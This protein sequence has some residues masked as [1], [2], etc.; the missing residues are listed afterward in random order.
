M[1]RLDQAINE[2]VN[3]M[4]PEDRIDQAATRVR[5]KLF[6]QARNGR[7]TG[8]AVAP[9]IRPSFPP[10]WTGRL[11]PAR[12]LLLQDHTRECPACRHALERARAG[13]VRTLRPSGDA[14]LAHHPEMV[15]DRRDARADTRRRS[16]HRQPDVL[17]GQRPDDGR[18]RAGHPLFGVG[19]RRDADLPGREIAEGQKIR[20]AKGSTAMVRLADGSLVELNERAEISVGRALRGTAIRLDR[21]NIIVQAA[22]QRHGTLDVLTPDC[23]V[24]VKGTIFAVDRGMKGSRVSVVEGS[25]QVAQGAAKQS[26]EA[27]PAGHHR[28]QCRG[29][30]GPGCD[31]MEPRFRAIPGLA[32][33]IQ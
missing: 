20:T 32:R 21:G 30:L 5:Q 12:A 17:R 16:A 6:P 11:T 33:R 19:P 9:I 10:I 13:N 8:S 26:A 14:P 4:I 2:I 27:R 29:H 18:Q 25:V 3:E 15:G 24:S 31:S 1:N 23:T 7:P 28:P 22:K